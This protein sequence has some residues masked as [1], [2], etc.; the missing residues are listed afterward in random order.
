M[1]TIA[2]WGAAKKKKNRIEQERE[3]KRETQEKKGKT[4]KTVEAKVCHI[5]H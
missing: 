1:V 2:A 5:C 4:E 3:K